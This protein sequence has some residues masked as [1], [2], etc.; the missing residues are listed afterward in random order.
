MGQKKLLI[1]LDR[2][3]N[4]VI[5]TLLLAIG[6]TNWSLKGKAYYCINFNNIK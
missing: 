6:T 1:Y 4:K 5:N 2:P 3:S